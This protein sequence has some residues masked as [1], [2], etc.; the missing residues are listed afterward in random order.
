[1][2]LKGNDLILFW[3]Q[4]GSDTWTTLAYARSCSLDI[5]AE[6]KEVGSP[7]TGS[8]S[9]YSKRKKSWSASSGH[10]SAGAS[11]LVTLIGLLNSDDEIPV[12]LSTI[13]SGGFDPATVQSDG[14]RTWTGQALL[15]KLTYTAMKGSKATLS[16]QLEGTGAL[17]H[18]DAPWI[19]ENGVWNDDG[20]WIDWKTWNDGT[21]EEE[22]EEIGVNPSDPEETLT[23]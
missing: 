5:N 12:M 15:T 14:R 17:T 1:M 6:M 3:K 16:I 2:K 22:E 8:S 23:E 7:D 10:L 4:P 20:V 11:Q 19:L 21:T 13:E 9:Q 18:A